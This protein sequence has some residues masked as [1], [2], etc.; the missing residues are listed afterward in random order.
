VYSTASQPLSPTSTIAEIVATWRDDFAAKI[1]HNDRKATTGHNYDKAI[2]RIGELAQ[3]RLCDLTVPAVKAWWRALYRDLGSAPAFLAYAALRA[4]LEWV[5]REGIV[6]YNV[7]RGIGISH[8]SK[9]TMPLKPEQT[10]ALRAA[11]DQLQLDRVGWL[12]QREIGG[13]EAVRYMS[14]TRA[15]ELINLT[16]RRP[17]EVSALLVADVDLST[18]TIT[19]EDT[20]TGPSVVILGPDAIDFVRLQL[21]ELG[22][23][24]RWLFPSPSMEGPI[25]RHTVWEM[26][27]RACGLAGIQNRQLR[28]LRNAWAW[29]ALF[30]GVGLEDT[31]RALGHRDLKTTQRAYGHGVYVTPGQVRAA[32]VVEQIRE[33]ARVEVASRRHSF[34]RAPRQPLTARHAAALPEAHGPAL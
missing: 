30:A 18:G 25:S 6:P 13:Y 34:R 1:S 10:V 12:D 9:K 20:K 2:A 7:A 11:I 32:H 8:R 21:E 4:A 14:A 28:G 3:V 24:S 16:G 5:R 23:R 33:R 19:M 29:A 26:F 22:G 17:G 27:H 15:L 31:G